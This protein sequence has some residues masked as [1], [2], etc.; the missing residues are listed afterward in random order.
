[1][2]ES[3]WRHQP[4]KQ[5]HH[6]F[7]CAVFALF[8]FL[9]PSRRG[10]LATVM[11]VFWTLF[12]LSVAVQTFVATDISCSPPFLC[13]ASMV[14]FPIESTNLSEVQNAGKTR[15]LPRSSCQRTQV[16]SCHAVIKPDL[17]R[18]LTCKQGGVLYCVSTKLF[19]RRRGVFRG[20]TLW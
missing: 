15:S 14:I 20:R 17:T 16:L 7:F 9:S 8:G 13:L 3:Q 10:S 19:P 18:Q 12:G 5:A 2:S 6:F 11:L 1:M 4:P